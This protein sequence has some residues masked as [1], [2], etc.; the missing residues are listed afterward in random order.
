MHDNNQ[1]IEQIAAY[2]GQIKHLKAKLKARGVTI[3]SAAA[4]DETPGKPGR[5]KR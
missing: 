3:P 2:E 1:M 4:T 5:R